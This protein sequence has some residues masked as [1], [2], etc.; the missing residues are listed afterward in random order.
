MEGCYWH[1]PPPPLRR[2]P[3][4]A[5]N[6]RTLSYRTGR[7]PSELEGQRGFAARLPTSRSDC[8]N[9]GKRP[10]VLARVGGREQ[11][12]GWDGLESLRADD[13]R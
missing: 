4:G 2:P 13:T 10:P 8:R 12:W 11:T 5:L 9:S 3:S 6:S 1:G 7:G